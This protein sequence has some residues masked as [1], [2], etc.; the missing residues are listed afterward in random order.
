MSSKR[1]RLDVGAAR[2]MN[3]FA[4]WDGSVLDVGGKKNH[5]SV[6][7]GTKPAP[8]WCPPGLSRT[9]K[10]RVQRLR[11]MEMT[12]KMEEEERDRWF[13]EDRPMVI[14][15]KTWREKRLA[16]EEKDDDNSSGS[17]K[18]EST[19]AQG[20]MDINMVFVLPTEFR[21]GE[22]DVAELT[23][24]AERAVFE[25]TSEQ[26]SHLKPL[27]VRGHIDGKPMGGMLVDGGA[28]V[29][30][31]PL[32]VFSKLG[33]K[34]SELIKTNMNLSGFSGEPSQAKGIMSVELTV[35]SKTVPTAFFVVDVKGRYNVLLG[36]DW[37]HA[38]GCVPST[39]H[40]FLVQWVG[41]QVEVIEAD[42]AMCIALM[43]TPM[44]WQHGNMRC[45]T[46]RDL[47]GYDFISVDRDSF[48]PIHVKPA[49]IARL[50]DAAL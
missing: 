20:D 30:V 22:G 29:N 46:G 18:E 2:E 7:P 28:G 4:S 48:V 10:R 8:R 42:T 49:D 19:E 37:I 36:R 44:E 26:G 24:G 35:G 5:C 3:N 39:L 43:E 47:S 33:Y 16:R 25:K 14:P 50:N 21:A 6:A 11:T 17:D 32:S 34:E 38:N 41:D 23:L 31:M 1:M 15:K 12:E 40:Q 45:L 13:N 9:Q 27:Y